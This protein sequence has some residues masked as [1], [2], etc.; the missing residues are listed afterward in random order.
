MPQ[1]FYALPIA[2]GLHTNPEYKT[3]YCKQGNI[4]FLRGKIIFDAAPGNFPMI[5]GSVPAGYNSDR[6]QD[7]EVFGESK[8]NRHVTATIRIQNTGTIYITSASW[9]MAAGDSVNLYCM[10]MIP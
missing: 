6:W 7:L 2:A 1:E 8:E 3:E 5:L 10:Y 9:Q 4:V